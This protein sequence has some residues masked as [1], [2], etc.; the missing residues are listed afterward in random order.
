[1]PLTGKERKA[2]AASANRLEAKIHV[3]P[4]AL[5][6]SVIAHLSTML[7]ETEL[8]KVRVNS[9]DRDEC[10]LVGME[11]VEKLGCE[12]VSRVGHVLV[13]YRA[14]PADPPPGPDEE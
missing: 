12:V 11:L 10:D 3:S 13:L 4:G 5:T 2:L 6:E 1:M 7:G 9:R 14:K 8:L